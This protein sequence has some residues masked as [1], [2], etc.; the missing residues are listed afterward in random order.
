V[1][2]TALFL[3]APL[4]HRG[5]GDGGPLGALRRS[6]FG[7]SGLSGFFGWTKREPNQTI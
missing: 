2:G 6:L 7:L 4:C 1:V 3:C 5:A